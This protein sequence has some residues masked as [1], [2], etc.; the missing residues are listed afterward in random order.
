M[1]EL[2]YRIGEEVHEISNPNQRLVIIRATGKLYHCKYQE[3]MNKP[4]IVYS[5]KEIKA[6]ISR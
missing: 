4:A 1:E 5:E 2:K 6:Y 3:D